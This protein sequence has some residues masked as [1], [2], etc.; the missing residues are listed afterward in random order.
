M[1]KTLLCGLLVA[2]AFCA[3]AQV[4]RQLWNKPGFDAGTRPDA[5]LLFKKENQGAD[6]E[7]PYVGPKAAAAT[8]NLP[9]SDYGKRIGYTAHDWQ[10]TTSTGNSVVKLNNNSLGVVWQFGR[11]F[12]VGSR[13]VGFN[14]RNPQGA[15]CVD[16]NATMAD[17]DSFR[18][19]LAGDN[20][21]G[22]GGPLSHVIIPGTPQYGRT[23]NQF[24]LPID[25][26]S[27]FRSFTLTFGGG[28]DSINNATRISDYVFP[29]A[30][31]RPANGLTLNRR[32]VIAY[33]PA[34]ASDWGNNIYGV[35]Y[36]NDTVGLGLASFVASGTQN[37]L[38][39]IKSTD[40]GNTWTS[41]I[42]P[43]LNRAFGFGS[44][45]TM[46]GYA[47][48][49]KGNQVVI[50][51]NVMT[52]YPNTGFAT[53]LL[54]S[55][56]G[57]DNFITQII[58]QASINDTNRVFE[59]GLPGFRACL[60][61]DNHFSVS[62]TPDDVVHI[63][64]SRGYLIGDSAAQEFQY[65]Y[66]NGGF[67]NRVAGR[68]MYWNSKMPAGGWVFPNGVDFVDTDRSG[69]VVFP[70][71]ASASA[72]GDY[73]QS[74]MSQSQISFDQ[75]GRIY[76]VYSALVE[77]T[78]SCCNPKVTRDIYVIA[79][80]D[81]G[82]TWTNPL[83]VAALAGAEDGVSGGTGATEDAFPTV[84]RV[85]TADDT[86][87]I[88][89]MTDET[90]GLQSNGV[91][92]PGYSAAN[93]RM[94]SIYNYNLHT[95]AI[96]ARQAGFTFPEAVCST[97]SFNVTLTI[98]SGVSVPAGTVWTVQ[99]DT[100][101]VGWFT[102]TI[103]INSTVVNNTVFTLGT[104]TTNTVGAN[105]IS[106]TIPAGVGVGSHKVRIIS[107][108]ADPFDISGG[109]V[110][111]STGRYDLAVTG[112]VPGAITAPSTFPAG[113]TSACPGDQLLLTAGTDPTAT[114]Y[115]WTSSV[116]NLATITPS[117]NA[118][119]VNFGR[120]FGPQPVTFTVTPKN[121]C[122][123]GPAA[124]I[125]INF[126]PAFLSLAGNQLSAPAGGSNH[127]WTL[128]GVP[129]PQFDGQATITVSTAPTAQGT[130]CVTAT[131]ISCS[132]C[133][134]VAIQS[135]IQEAN[136]STNLNIYP[137]P[138]QGAFAV[139]VKNW[140]GDNTRA[141]VTVTNTL[142]QVVAVKDLQTAGS[143]AEARFSTEGFAKGIYMVR[144]TSGTQSVTRR[145]VVE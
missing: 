119:F 43:N 75:R 76:V 25:G 101:R 143:I 91:F 4:G 1:R 129:Q 94:N 87:H 8:T 19:V 120:Q 103:R 144:V 13:Q 131:G 50:V 107:N 111:Y 12:N 72:P 99:M 116:P 30:D 61:N 89:W 112:G 51:A 125:T 77:G 54:R 9:A 135:G 140:I 16:A 113:I 141:S 100:S 64:T 55:F 105:V 92:A 68:L 90:S 121:G 45:H 81:S 31:C 134:N 34:L 33:T 139:E 98:P 82:K 49:V 63:T 124:N 32:G 24:L 133:L 15:W 79:S 44:P 27:N 126:A 106:C 88:F 70:A 42:I 56:D 20:A 52:T 10:Y 22:V 66:R 114:D 6:K 35:T 60:L 118:A 123:N 97:T 7:A 26:N 85:I 46:G 57:G 53:V 65:G 138:A 67:T 102:P 84:N 71:S 117:S 28:L 142:G 36:T 136:L 21:T 95:S 137:N 5:N 127:R 96:W 104:S 78:E 83:N 145:V 41:K 58:D 29:S 47:I 38:A 59:V 40:Q 23:S 93:W 11:R 37:P 80:A 86:L 14:F 130:Y 115:I 48:D 62:I 18:F 74:A 108:F 73:M 69:T 110:F 132:G 128:N 109:Q 2:G 122:G 39:F 3:E 17:A